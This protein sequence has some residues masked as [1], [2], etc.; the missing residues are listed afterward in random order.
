MYHDTCTCALCIN[1]M[2]AIGCDDSRDIH[3]VTVLKKKKKSQTLM[4]SNSNFLSKSQNLIL[5]KCGA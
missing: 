2:F 5:A 4:H 1:V 3:Y